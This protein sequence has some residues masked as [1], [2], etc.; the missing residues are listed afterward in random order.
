MTWR[1]RGPVSIAR[2]GI[3][4]LCAWEY[5]GRWRAMFYGVQKGPYATEAEARVAVEAFAREK[6]R[7]AGR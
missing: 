5:K 1:Q 3:F 4:E 2:L 7:E 6:V